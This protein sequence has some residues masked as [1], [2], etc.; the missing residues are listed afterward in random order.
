VVGL[1]G[2]LDMAPA[3]GANLKRKLVIEPDYFIGVI[4][5]PSPERLEVIRREL[6]AVIGWPRKIGGVA[7]GGRGHVVE[8]RG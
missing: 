4:E 3:A 1:W 5:D 2:H 7:T 8:G 6:Y